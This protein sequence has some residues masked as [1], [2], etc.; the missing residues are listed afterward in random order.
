MIVTLSN[1]TRNDIGGNKLSNKTLLI[2]VVIFVA[3]IVLIAVKR[4]D[5]TPGSM[6]DEVGFAPLAPDGFLA[7]N[8]R[9][10]EVFAGNKVEEKLI[11]SKSDDK[12]V[13]T[14]KF[15]APADEEKVLDLL[16]K[17]KKLK[18]EQRSDAPEVVG[19]YGLDD[20]AALHYAVYTDREEAT[21]H[22]LVGKGDWRNTFVRANNSSVVHTVPLNLR[23]EA[24]YHGS[25]IDKAPDSKLWL[26]KQIIDVAED[27]ISGLKIKWP[28]KEVGFERV[29]R[30][31]E[32]TEEDEG[33]EEEEKPDMPVYE[34]R[35]VSGGV[36]E[37]F[38][39]SKLESILSEIDDLQ[40]EDAVD[41]SR[42][43]AWGLDDPAW[44]VHLEMEEGD[45]TSLLG[46]R[47]TVMGEGYVQVE[48]ATMTY[49]VTKSTFEKVFATGAE[50]FS[51]SG[52]EFDG[53][54]IS[55]MEVKHSG[56]T[57]IF[58]RD[59]NDIWKL[60][61]PE[62]S[63]NLQDDVAD[64]LANAIATWKPIDYA[65]GNDLAVYGLDSPRATINFS[66][67]NGEK[68]TVR[69]G[70][71]SKAV[72]GRYVLTDDG[73]LILTASQSDFEELTPDLADLLET[74][75]LNVDMESVQSVKFAGP[76]ESF[77]LSG[78][79][80]TWEMAIGEESF[81]ADGNRVEDLLLDLSP[82]E[83]EDYVLPEQ[84]DDWKVFFSLN[85]ETDKEESITIELSE[86]NLARI[87]RNGEEI[88]LLVRID[89][90]IVDALTP[91]SDSLRKEEEDKKE[92]KNQ[93]STPEE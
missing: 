40:A 66:M 35:L 20:E 21:M 89:P 18:G 3:I 42:K 4:V 48:G 92:D 45:S 62:T 52:F 34:W 11:I 81:T 55:Q 82:L 28:D 41:P 31:K 14:S 83:A 43:E 38:E 51:L 72:E 5:N 30:P 93:P 63:I 64:D 73:S 44:V 71:A 58:E 39:E 49:K 91:T 37:G 1:S 33:A 36:G 60:T 16:N 19:D 15:D 6:V 87:R 80:G 78:A 27:K 2:L 24:G 56:I 79:E 25:D 76:K 59:R 13:V 70:A 67:E 8:V 85:I 22:L 9:R 69:I 74:E 88:N 77:V 7:S 26:D 53:E 46:G 86:D 32:P 54:E 75:V 65:D 23:S 57:F 84:R 10:L 90:K 68:H 47:P 12:W 17:F 29:E 50:L 61:S